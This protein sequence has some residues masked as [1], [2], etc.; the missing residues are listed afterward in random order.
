MEFV[1]TFQD[2]ELTGPS[3]YNGAGCAHLNSREVD[4]LV[5]ADH[6]F[7]NELTA[8]KLCTLG[9]LKGGSYL[10]SCVRSLPSIFKRTLIHTGKWSLTDALESS[11]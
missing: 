3:Q 2:E 8:P 4:E 6:D 9:I 10:S 11:L 5:F 1:A 7:F